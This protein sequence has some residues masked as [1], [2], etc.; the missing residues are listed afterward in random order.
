MPLSNSLENTF[1]ILDDCL[2]SVTISR[3]INLPEKMQYLSRVSRARTAIRYWSEVAG[4]Q[5]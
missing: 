4:F 2:W 3:A 1:E 5:Y